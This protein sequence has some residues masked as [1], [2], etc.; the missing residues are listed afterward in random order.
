MALDKRNPRYREFLKQSAAGVPFADAWTA[1]AAADA[2][3][4]AH[5]A[6]ARRE[7]NRRSQAAYRQ[8]QQ[9]RR[10]DGVR[11]DVCISPELAQRFAAFVASSGMDSAAVLRVALESVMAAHGRGAGVP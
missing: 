4:R 5:Q 9:Q 7:N 1:F 11:L 6:E 8:R 3:A 10:G 2:A